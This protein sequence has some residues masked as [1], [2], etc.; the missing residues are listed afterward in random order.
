MTRFVLSLALLTLLAGNAPHFA[1][2]AKLDEAA[3]AEARG[4]FV[5]PNG[6]VIA[7]AVATETRIDGQLAV[8]STFRIA[9]GRPVVTIEGRDAATGE[10]TTLNP[11]AAGAAAAGGTIRLGGDGSRIVFNGDRIDVSH[12]IGRAFGSAIAN[13]A[14]NRTIDVATSIDID[15][16]GATPDLIGSAMLRADN[17]AATATDL[18]RR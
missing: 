4:G 17:L 3:L 9:D 15:V 14:D 7:L 11:G 8:R 18:V 2:G 12:L 6:L 10:L 1:D 5:L 16:A 13:S